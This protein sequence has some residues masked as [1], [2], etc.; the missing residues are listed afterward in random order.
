MKLI[1]PKFIGGTD[2]E[3][4]DPEEKEERK[5]GYPGTQRDNIVE[6]NYLPQMALR[7]EVSFLPLL[8]SV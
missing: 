4:L 5:I 6:A 7:Q 3:T 8:K 2:F 1:A